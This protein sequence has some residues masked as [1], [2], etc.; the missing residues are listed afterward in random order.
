MKPSMKLLMKRPPQY[1]MLMSHFWFVPFFSYCSC[2]FAHS[3][4]IVS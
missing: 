4:F 2:G 1:V 3:P